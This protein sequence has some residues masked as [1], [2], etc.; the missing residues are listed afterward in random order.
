MTSDLVAEIRQQAE[1]YLHNCQYQQAI[2]YYEAAIEAEP[3][4]KYYYFYL[5]LMLLLE[6]QEE[7][8]QITWLLAINEED[9]EP[10]EYWSN[11]L[12]NILYQEAN[13]QAQLE[14]HQLAWVIRQHLRELNPTDIHNLLALIDLSIAI[15]AYTPDIIKDYGIIDILQNSSLSANI[16]Q[17][18]L[19]RVTE[20]VLQVATLEPSSL[21]L[22]TAMIPYVTSEEKFIRVIIDM[23]FDLARTAHQHLK[24]I[25]LCQIGLQ[26]APRSRELLNSLAALFTD[27]G[28]YPQGIE[29]AKRAY[30]VVE[31]IPEKLCQSFTILKALLTAGGYWDELWDVVEQHK[32]LI[33]Q[34][35]VEHPKNL[36]TS[37]MGVGLY[38]TSFYFAYI[39]DNP[40]ENITIRKQISQVCQSNMEIA[41]PQLITKF[42]GR[43]T[44][45]RQGVQP[46]PRKLKIGYVSS[47]LRRHSVGWLARSLFQYGDRHNFEIYTYMT[48][49][50]VFYDPIQEW[51]I[52]NS[53]HIHK[54]SSVK[55]ELAEQIY[56]DQIDI[57]VDMDSLTT[58]NMS[59]IM[60]L[61][62]API[63]VT[64]L[65]WDASAVPTVDY[66]MADPYVL[67]ENAQ[68]YYQETIWRLPQ[69]YL[70]VDGFEVSVP[71]ITRADLEIPDDAIVYLGLQKGPK[72]NPHIAKLQLEILREV[73]NSYFLVKGFGQQD[74]FSKFFFDIANQQGITT[75]RIKF[76]PTVKL[77]ENHRANLLIADVVLDTYPYNGATT[78][79]ETLWMGIPLVTRVGE[80]FAARNSYTMMMN[81]GITEGIAWTDEEYV[82]WG[83]RL[84][85]DERLRQDISWKLHKSRRTA[86]LWNGK[87]FTRDMEKAYQ[88][89]WQRYIDGGSC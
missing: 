72:Y 15:N 45:L 20:K 74:S 85:T 73:P 34:L 42:R 81:A 25:E 55:L 65:G 88:E 29:Y 41:F 53:D 18:L 11:E 2:R 31:T 66:F 51:Y 4:N 52:A 80:Q 1:K 35:I 23:T 47:C 76:I 6:G 57:L 75:D 7:E 9:I 24:A 14:N 40:R 78:T 69:T 49:S 79:M 83:V 82:E 68:E 5:G 71:T 54:Y 22:L 27:I 32:L 37:S 70:A 58:S 21:E 10:V 87:Q 17:E 19:I 26:L 61:K 59:A 62:P 56:A 67:P 46:S 84:G 43:H 12:S 44:S 48:E 28:D 13:R 60:A 50:R 36:G 63:Q 38:I 33:D 64:W 3:N 16:N 86:P 77:E 8:A 39:V 89:M 30:S